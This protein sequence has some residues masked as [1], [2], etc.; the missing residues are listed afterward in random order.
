[1]Q[2]KIAAALIGVLAL[3]TAVMA[4]E[5]ATE[6]V[7]LK[8]EG[9]NCGK[10]ATKIETELKAV[11]GVAAAD[12]SLLNESAEVVVNKGVTVAALTAAVNKAGYRVAGQ[13]DQ[14]AA[15]AHKDGT[16]CGKKCP[17]HSK[18]KKGQG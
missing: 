1:M 2:R 10:C 18:E 4:A 17:M 11:P 12:V 14:E 7:S 6:K 3:A 15:Q 9:M 5:A 16:D 13:K 8:I